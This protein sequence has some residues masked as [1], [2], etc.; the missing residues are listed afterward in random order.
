MVLFANFEHLLYFGRVAAIRIVYLFRVQF[1]HL[2][3]SDEATLVAVALFRQVLT[4]IVP[5]FLLSTP[6]VLLNPIVT[7]LEHDCC[8]SYQHS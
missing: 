5:D 7:N 4:T 6:S 8:F 1:F 3:T 2:L